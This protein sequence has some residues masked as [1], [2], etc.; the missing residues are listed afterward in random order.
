MASDDCWLTLY[1]PLLL[2]PWFFRYAQTRPFPVIANS[3]EYWVTCYKQARL[4]SQYLITCTYS[5]YIANF[6][7]YQL[8][9]PMIAIYSWW[10]WNLIS[11]LVFP[12]YSHWQCVCVSN[13][14]DLV[15][16]WEWGQAVRVYAP[17]NAMPHPYPM[18]PGWGKDGD[19]T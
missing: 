15:I 16:A 17:I 10:N 13:N 8:Y 5:I 18:G 3:H 9:T 7:E 11:S 19:L 12:G 2:H 4:H 6:P 14:Q 1:P